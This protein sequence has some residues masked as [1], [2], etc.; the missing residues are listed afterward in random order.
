MGRH[1]DLNPG[2]PACEPGVVAIT[3]RGLQLHFVAFITSEVSIFELRL[4][5]VSDECLR[6]G[7]VDVLCIPADVGIE[8]ECR[9]AIKKTVQHFGRKVI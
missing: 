1:R 6:L 9:D 8:R 5:E 4:K 3:L 7:A 2:P